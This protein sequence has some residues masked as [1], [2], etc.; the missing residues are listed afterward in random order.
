[1]ILLKRKIINFILKEKIYEIEKIK[2]YFKKP[3][4]QMRNLSK[5]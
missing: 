2:F 1:M 3:L 5:K 4:H